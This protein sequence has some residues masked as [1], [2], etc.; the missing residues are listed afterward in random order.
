MVNNE[1]KVSLYYLMTSFSSFAIGNIRYSAKAVLDR[2]WKSDKEFRLPFTVIK[3]HDL[4]LSPALYIPSK[5]EIVRH[6]YCCCI[7]SK[8]F[9]MSASIPF[10]GLLTLMIMPRKINN[11]LR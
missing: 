2:P 9:F 8:P 7:R 11:F 6:F 5:S 4:N 10:S 1:F 3:T